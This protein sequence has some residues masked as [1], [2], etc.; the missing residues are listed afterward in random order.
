MAAGAMVSS[1]LHLEDLWYTFPSGITPWGEPVDD[2]SEEEHEKIEE[3]LAKLCPPTCIKLLQINGYFARRLPQWMRTMSTFVKLTRF[4]LT[5]YPRGKQLPIG[6]GQLP[7]LDYIYVCGPSVQCIGHDFLFP[8]FGGE[9]D[10][11]N[12]VP[13]ATHKER[14]QPR[15]ASHGAGVAF[16]K[17]KFLGLMGMLEWTEWEWEQNIPAMTVLEKLMLGNGKLQRLPKGLAKH[18]CQLRDLYLRNAQQLVSVENFPSLVKL[19]LINNVRLERI[20]NIPSLQWMEITTC[21]ALK[22]LDDLPSLRSIEWRDVDAEA[23]PQYL[24]EVNLK[25]L[26]VDCSR[27]LLKLIASQDESSEWGKIQHVQKLK[28]YG[29]KTEEDEEADGYIYYTREPYSFDV[30]LGK[31]TG[32]FTFHLLSCFIIVNL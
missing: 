4:E 13:V 8:S 15:H 9:A 24:Q 22:E 1:K 27:S 19:Q 31:S 29:H 7:S 10:V 14:R 28:A 26:R 3:V 5:P 11:K 2:I 32:I 20:S 21:R 18:A 30:Y 17:L 16:P 6:L 23:L 25:N 12:E